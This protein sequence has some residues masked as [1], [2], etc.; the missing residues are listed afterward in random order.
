[1]PGSQSPSMLNRLAVWIHARPGFAVLETHSANTEL[2][3]LPPSLQAMRLKPSSQVL[4]LASGVLPV[5]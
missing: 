2:C 1:M 3:L 5:P 4:M